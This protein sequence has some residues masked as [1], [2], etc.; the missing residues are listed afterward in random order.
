MMLAGVVADG[1]DHA[2]PSFGFFRSFWPFGLCLRHAA[3]GAVIFKNRTQVFDHSYNH[4][5]V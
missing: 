4:L 3:A 2:G 1:C 5:P